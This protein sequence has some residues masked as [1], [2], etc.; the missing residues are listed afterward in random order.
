MNKSMNEKLCSKGVNERISVALVAE[1][2]VQW[3]EQ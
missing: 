3:L 2:T 1:F